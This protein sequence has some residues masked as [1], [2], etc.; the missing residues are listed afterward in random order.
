MAVDAFHCPG[1]A[2]F[3]FGIPPIPSPPSTQ[4]NA[5]HDDCRYRWILHTGDFRADE[6][7]TNNPILKE[8]FSTVH[9]DAIY[10]DTTYCDPKYTFPKQSAVVD[11]CCRVV[12]RLIKRT[13]VSG[14]IP[15][16][17]LV[18]VGTYL[19]GKEKVAVVVARMLKSKIFCS[20]RKRLALRAMLWP[21]IEQLLTEDPLEASVHLVSLGDLTEE[22][23]GKQLDQYWPRF[24]HAL[25]LRPTGWAYKPGTSAVTGKMSSL[26]HYKR[27][28]N[29][30][31]VK[32]KDAISLYAFAYSEHSSFPE[33]VTFL[34]APWLH[35]D[36]LIPTVD[37]THDLYL[38]RCDFPD[39]ESLL[40]FW[41]R[42]RQH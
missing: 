19:I 34:S 12:E 30:Q 24:T 11:G 17:R 6:A 18:L 20:P 28:G 38:Q 35:Y 37:N 15:R 13:D 4:P 2:I 40:L 36:R 5:K 1:S 23:I 29:N 7:L 8:N 16:R 10:L 31:M 32:R 33:L 9:F 3:A 39:P 22:G 21:E 26:T 14:F 27:D 25:A 41:S 42:A